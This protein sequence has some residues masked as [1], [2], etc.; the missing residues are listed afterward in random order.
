MNDFYEM[1]QKKFGLQETLLLKD[2]IEYINHKGEKQQKEDSS[3][4][5]DDEISTSYQLKNT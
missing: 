3:M 1:I 2:L 4:I 5:E